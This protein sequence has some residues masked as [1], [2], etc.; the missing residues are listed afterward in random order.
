MAQHARTT[1]R[2]DFLTDPHAATA[3]AELMDEVFSIDV[4]ARDARAGTD[5][6]WTPFA[7]FTDD[8]AC[9]ASVEAAVLRLVCDGGPVEATGLRSVAVH[10]DWRGRGLFR[11]LTLQ[12]LDWCG[13]ICGPVLLYTGEPALYT[14]FGF[15]PVAQH[16]FAGACPPVAAGPPARTLELDDAADLALLTRLLT[17]RAPV[18]DR[19]AMIHAPSLL[20]TALAGSDD[21][22]AAHVPALD[23]IAIFE[24]DDDTLI[25]ADVVAPAIPP[26]DALLAALPRR[27]RLETLFPP[28]RLGWAGAPEPDDTGL[29]ARGSVPEAMRRPFRLPPTTEF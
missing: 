7:A 12:A 1:T 3:Y 10:P 17:T 28:D 21:L 11:D 19:C 27:R 22:V 23:A 14:R 15:A 13:K 16:A 26:L 9:V 2:H 6:A 4:A 25:L 20:L 8:G 24:I 5:P 29:M 18:S